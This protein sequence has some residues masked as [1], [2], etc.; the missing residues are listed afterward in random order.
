[1]VEI[2]DNFID[3]MDLNEI[4]E[5]LIAT[6][7]IGVSEIEYEVYPMSDFLDLPEKNEKDIKKNIK[8]AGRQLFIAYMLILDD[9]YKKHYIDKEDLSIDRFKL[10]DEKKV[11]DGLRYIIVAMVKI[12]STLDVSKITEDTEYRVKQRLKSANRYI[13]DIETL[14]Y[15]EWCN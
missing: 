6:V 2:K 1:M 7:L 11:I 13:E 5:L 3:E 15:G 4:L 12:K 9:I 10:L 14:Y 8:L